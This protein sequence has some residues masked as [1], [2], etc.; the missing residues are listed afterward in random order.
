MKK[1]NIAALI[2][3]FQDDEELFNSCIE[4]LDS[5]NG[6]LNDDRYYEMDMLPEI[7]YGMDTMEVLQKAYFGKDEDGGPDSSFNPNREYFR[8]N[9][10]GNLVS[11]DYKDYSGY[12]DEYFVEQLAENIDEIQTI[13]DDPDLLELF[14]G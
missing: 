3:R 9:G 5:Y 1:E 13:Q 14:Q 6:Y 4:D 8:F 10:Y 2:Q 12:L 7:L 11:A